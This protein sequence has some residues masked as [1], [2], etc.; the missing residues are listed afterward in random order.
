MQGQKREV[1]SFLPQQW[2]NFV[3]G[4]EHSENLCPSN[5]QFQQ[6]NAALNIGVV[7][8][9]RLVVIFCC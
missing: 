8:I 1:T 4:N 7:G 3:L 6:V 2:Q 9:G 5:K